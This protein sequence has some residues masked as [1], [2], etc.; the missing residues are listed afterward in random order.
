[1]TT[2]GSKREVEPILAEGEDDG[3]VIV[4]LSVDSETNIAELG[5]WR[6]DSESDDAAQNSFD[7]GTISFDEPDW[8]RRVIVLHSTIDALLD[9]LA[10]VPRDRLHQA[11]TI[12]RL[13]LT[14]PAGAET[15]SAETVKRIAEVNA[16]L[17]IDA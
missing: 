6:M 11:G 2:K 1:V 5:R 9:R 4:S 7:L 10:E 3:H 14:L 8:E 13:F 15:I 16:V 12:V 17:W